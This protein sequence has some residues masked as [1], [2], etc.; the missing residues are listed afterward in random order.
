MTDPLT[1]DSKTRTFPPAGFETARLRLRRFK[2]GDA[3][4]LY[5]LYASDPDTCR[6]MSFKCTG[7]ILETEAFV[8]T[9]ARAW[10]SGVLSEAHLAWVIELKP[11][12]EA[13]GSLG[14][15]VKNAHTIVGGCILNP[16][17]WR[18]GYAAEAW[19]CLLD[20]LI[21]QPWVFR[22]EAV[23]DVENP[24]SA[25]VM[26]KSG[27]KYEGTLRR[28]SIHPNRS[29]EPRDVLLYAWARE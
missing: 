23:C 26:E 8:A 16:R 7:R 11:A 13:I 29:S 12:G 25:R 22:V 14:F 3:S 15:S 6:Y 9:C 27:M 24:A 4:L 5:N 1:A 10:D 21:Q 28:H 2:T 19:Q 17:F 18:Q 20:W